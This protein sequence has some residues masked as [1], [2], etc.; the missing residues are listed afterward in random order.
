M[1]ILQV[2]KCRLR[3][4]GYMVVT[5]VLASCSLLQTAKELP[6]GMAYL[7]QA[8]AGRDFESFI[9]K[10]T[11]ESELFRRRMLAGSNPNFASA[12][13]LTEAILRFRQ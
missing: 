3:Q 1:S 10:A 6:P 13:L 7:K 11:T 9:E 5:I 4:V 8:P 12:D 2:K